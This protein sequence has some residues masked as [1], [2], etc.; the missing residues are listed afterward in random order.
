MSMNFVKR[1]GHSSTHY[2]KQ[3]RKLQPEQHCSKYDLG[4]SYCSQKSS[5]HLA[6]TTTVFMVCTHNN[7][8]HTMIP[9]LSPRKGQETESKRELKVSQVIHMFMGASGL[10]M[11]LSKSLEIQVSQVTHPYQLLLPIPP[12]IQPVTQFL[13][14][15]THC[16]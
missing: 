13:E 6:S 8:I 10:I 2:T 4:A 1:R 9:P 16:H 12:G 7:V 11:M 15:P 14:S 5:V 3:I